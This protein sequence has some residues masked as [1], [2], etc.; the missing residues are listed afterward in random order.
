MQLP[1]EERVCIVESDNPRSGALAP[2]G[3][4]EKSLIAT[5]VNSPKK[6][7]R[8]PVELLLLVGISACINVKVK[9]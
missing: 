6:F 8:S 4:R 7:V 3:K 2:C 5:T 1:G 9:T